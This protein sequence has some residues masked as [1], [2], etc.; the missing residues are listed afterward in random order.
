MVSQISDYTNYNSYINYTNSFVR[1]TN[2]FQGSKN[3]KLR[4]QLLKFLEL[5]YYLKFKMFCYTVCP[6][7]MQVSQ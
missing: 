5:L 3:I 1:W 6:F 4:S 2:S 7:I